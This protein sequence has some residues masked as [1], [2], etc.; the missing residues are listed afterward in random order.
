MKHKY[1]IGDMFYKRCEDNKVHQCEILELF[2][3]QYLNLHDNKRYPSYKMKIFGDII[4]DTE[5]NIP[6]PDVQVVPECMLFKNKS[7]AY[8]TWVS[9]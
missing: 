4:T 7:D 9:E 5:F 8:Y 2:H 1:K 6:E 3:L